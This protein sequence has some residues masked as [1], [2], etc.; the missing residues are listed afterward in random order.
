MKVPRSLML[1]CSMFVIQMLQ[2]LAT[3]AIAQTPKVVPKQGESKVVP[4]Q[5]EYT[6]LNPRG[7]PKPVE[8]VAPSPRLSSLSGKTVYLV[9]QKGAGQRPLPQLTEALNKALPDTKFVLVGKA[10][11]FATEEPKLWDEVAKNA[12]ALIYGVG[13]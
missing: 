4:K 11:F 1:T 3:S 10:G 9:G 5:G 6:V 7:L 12:D 13:D 8:R 2:T